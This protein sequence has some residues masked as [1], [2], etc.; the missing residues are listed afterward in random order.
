M[1]RGEVAN[2]D[3]FAAF[4]HSYAAAGIGDPGYHRER[5]QAAGI[6]NPGYSS[7]DRADA[8]VND[9]AQYCSNSY[10]GNIPLQKRDQKKS[11]HRDT[12]SWPINQR[13]GN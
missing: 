11:S 2:D 9:S 1:T 6:A 3:I 12:D 4:S 8:R 10:Q 5:I 7:H 13:F